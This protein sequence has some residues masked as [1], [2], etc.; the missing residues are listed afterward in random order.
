MSIEQ[1]LLRNIQHIFLNKS[2]I[3]SNF[4]QEEEAYQDNKWKIILIFRNITCFSNLTTT[5]ANNFKMSLKYLYFLFLAYV[6]F[7][8]LTFVNFCEI[9]KSVDSVFTWFWYPCKHTFQI[10]FQNLY[11]LYWDVSIYIKCRLLQEN[12]WNMVFIYSQG[13][14]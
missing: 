10:I 14:L 11:I 2:N 5:M 13:L 1:G 9:I 12:S 8:R 6:W 4:P 3:W 7:W